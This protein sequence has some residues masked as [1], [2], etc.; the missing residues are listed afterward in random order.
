MAQP[1]PSSSSKKTDAPKFGADPRL[2]DAVVRVQQ[3][4]FPV[5]K[6]VLGEHS[7]V[8]YNIFF[9]E[10]KESTDENPIEFDDLREF[11]FQHFLEVIN[12]QTNI[13]DYSVESVLKMARRFECEQLE[14]RCVS[15]MMHDSRESLKNRFKWAFEFDLEELKTKVL[16]EVKTIKELKAVMP[17]SDVSTYGP[18][19]TFLLFEK[20]LDVQGIRKKIGPPIDRMRLIRRLE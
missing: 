14:R 4:N 8:F 7:K 17:S 1:G 6:C 11:D 10:K 19:D 12:G 15:H 2:F 9:V 13:W 20:S 16:S 18:E 3:Q 5:K